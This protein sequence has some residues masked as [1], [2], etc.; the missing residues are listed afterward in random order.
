MLIYDADPMRQCGACTLCCKLVP[1]KEI[2]KRAGERCQHQRHTGCAIYSRRP[3]SCMVWSCSW[4]LGDDT[5]ELRR[6]DRSRYVIDPMPD[7]VSVGGQRVQVV[8]I[9]CDPKAP[10]AWQDP[11]LIAFLQRKAAEGVG[12]LIRY[13]GSE[14]KAVFVR[15][16]GSWQVLESNV[17][18]TQEDY[19]QKTRQDATRE[20][21]R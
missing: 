15:Q 12:A 5:K 7:Q 8:Q 11:A 9:W 19:E 10:D 16:D 4:L 17:H 3:M 20:L 18:P 1:V 21:T 13:S 6:P 2:G 14:G